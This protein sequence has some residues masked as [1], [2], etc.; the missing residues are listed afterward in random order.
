MYNNVYRAMLKS[1]TQYAMH[2]NSA[3]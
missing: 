3:P 1:K 2:T